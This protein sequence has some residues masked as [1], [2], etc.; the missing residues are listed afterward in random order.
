M[1]QAIFKF[2]DHAL[3][4]PQFL[5]CGSFNPLHAGHIS[6]A[7]FIYKKYEV[8]VDFEISLH[9]VEKLSINLEEAKLR[10]H[11]MLGLKTPAFGRL[12]ITDDD[13]RYLEKA[14]QLPEV[15]FV[16]GFDTIRALC[17]GRYYKGK[18]FE[19]AINEFNELEIKWLVFPR[20]KEDGNYSTPDDFRDFPSGL[21]KNITIVT[22]DEFIPINLSSRELRDKII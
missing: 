3:D 18:E 22:T 4:Y 17:D 21:L 9:N 11:Q 8:P 5:F 12:Y 19:Q 14:Y 13:A 2:N 16:C 1:I 20:K 7:D 15:T 10:Y 6:I